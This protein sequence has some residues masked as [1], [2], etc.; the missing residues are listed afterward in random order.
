MGSSSGVLRSAA[1]LS[2]RSALSSEFELLR[3]VEIARPDFV[4]DFEESVKAE[5][6]G[7]GVCNN[8][9]F[10]RL[11]YRLKEQVARLRGDGAGLSA[12]E[13]RGA[14]YDPFRL[15]RYL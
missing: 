15:G 8:F 9:Q 4:R 10:F 2:L 14:D 6:A 5:I 3:A 13:Q 12:M 1:G 7:L 11:L